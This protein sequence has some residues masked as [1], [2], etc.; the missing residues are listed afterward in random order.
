[1]SSSYEFQSE[2]KLLVYIIFNL[3]MK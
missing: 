3:L 2:I 1:M